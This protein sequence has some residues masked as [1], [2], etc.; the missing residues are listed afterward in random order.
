MSSKQ[1]VAA[2]LAMLT[3]CGLVKVGPEDNLEDKM[4]VWHL[5]LGDVVSDSVLKDATLAVCR[6]VE[7]QYGVI[8]PRDLMAAAERLRKGRIRETCKRSPIPVG[9]RDAVDQ[10]AYARGWLWAVGEGLSLEEAD[11]NGLAA[12]VCYKA[13]EGREPETRPERLLSRLSEA[14]KPDRV[15][16]VGYVNKIPVKR[17]TAAPSGGEDVDPA[18]VEAVKVKLQA[19]AGSH[20]VP[21]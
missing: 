13:V 1:A 3:E 4:N 17:L 14:I 21:N 20:V 19:L 12:V 8:T 2:A 7:K 11:R 9:D 18:Q 6:A 16:W 15:P 5:V 10:C